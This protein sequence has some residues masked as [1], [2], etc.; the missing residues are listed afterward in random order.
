MSGSLQD[1]QL[2]YY[3]FQAVSVNA[4]EVVLR[5]TYFIELALENI[6]GVVS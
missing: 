5:G 6:R 1:M 2:L 3:P 4:I